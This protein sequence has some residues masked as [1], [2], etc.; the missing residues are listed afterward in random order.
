MSFQG[1]YG[2]GFDLPVID[3]VM[4]A[5]EALAKGDCVTLSDETQAFGQATDEL[6][7]KVEIPSGGALKIDGNVNGIMGVCLE[8]AAS[9]A[10]LRVRF[11][12]YVDAKVDSGVAGAIG[13][14]LTVDTDGELVV[15]STTDT[16]P[17]KVVAFTANT[18]TTAL[19]RVLF[20]GINGLGRT[21][22]S[23]AT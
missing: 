19:R 12:G 23:T 6:F 1:S 17:N 7:Y 5:G 15:A 9:G 22:V 3:A 4:I 14:G 8:D 13:S 21:A 20:S 2:G 11:Q 10:K 16:I 18:D